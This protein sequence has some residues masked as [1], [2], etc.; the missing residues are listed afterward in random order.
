MTHKHKFYAFC[1]QCDSLLCKCCIIETLKTHTNH[2]VSLID[3]QQLSRRANEI[4][5][6]IQLE[7]DQNKQFYDNLLKTLKDTQTRNS[8]HYTKKIASYKEMRAKLMTL[9]G[10]LTLSASTYTLGSL[11]KEQDSARQQLSLTQNYITQSAP[12]HQSIQKILSNPLP[13]M[14]SSLPLCQFLVSK[15]GSRVDLTTPPS[16]AEASAS[17]IFLTLKQR[18]SEEFCKLS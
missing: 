12:L 7:M 17:S 14:F 8:E 13:S 5:Q 15:L 4:K 9:M 11:Q 1:A 10:D 18:A 2:E 3:D 6:G 16:T